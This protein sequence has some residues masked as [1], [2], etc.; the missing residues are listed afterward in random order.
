M[1]RFHLFVL[2]I[3]ALLGIDSVAYSAC[4]SSTPDYNTLSACVAAADRNATISVLAGDGTETWGSTLTLTKGVTL[5]GPGRDSLVITRS[6]TA[7]SI[8]PDS[9]AL[10]NAETIKI[11]G[12]TF[13]GNNSAL[14]ILNATTSGS[15][16]HSF[17]IVIGD[18]RFKNNSTVT[19]N[20]GAISTW[21]QF[22]G[23]IYLSL[24]HI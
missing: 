2:S 19:S 3:I 21:G 1:M 22:R 5:T 10:S 13:D 15:L 20:N 24:I 18:N 14:V 8:E 7:I 16:T 9:T 23:V 11:T 12:F 6:G 17:N 4:T